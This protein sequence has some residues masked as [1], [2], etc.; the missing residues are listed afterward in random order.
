LDGQRKLLLSVS[1]L[2]LCSFVQWPVGLNQ[3]GS[4]GRVG[5]SLRRSPIMFLII[6]NLSGSFPIT[7]LTLR[8]TGLYFFLAAL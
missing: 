5:K 4:V 6:L 3:G 1:N 7:G 8:C 2:S